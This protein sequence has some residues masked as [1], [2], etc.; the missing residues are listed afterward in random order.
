MAYIQDIRFDHVGKQEGFICDQ[1]GAYITNVYTVTY[2]NGLKM[3]YGMECF[4][5]LFE[6]GRLT[7]QGIKLMK[8]ALKKIKEAYVIRDAWLKVDSFEEAKEQNIPYW[9]AFEYEAWKGRNFEEFKEFC[10]SETKGFFACSIRDVRKILERF[11]K[12]NFDLEKVKE[13]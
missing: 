11:N 2:S 6:A 4:K 3:Q 5:K 12:V 9:S 10:T 8:K 1:C 13:F 7:E